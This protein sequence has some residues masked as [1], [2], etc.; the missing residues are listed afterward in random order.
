[1]T[2][3][4]VRVT[5]Q[6]I[7]SGK[8]HSERWCPVTF[9]IRRATKRP[10]VVTTRYIFWRGRGGCI[11]PVSVSQWIEAYNKELYSV[12]P[13]IFELDWPDN[14]KIRSKQLNK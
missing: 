7:N 13:F 10:V 14:W 6:D 3:V 2:T 5:Q 11:L 9:A 12:E 4:K 8:P 1:M